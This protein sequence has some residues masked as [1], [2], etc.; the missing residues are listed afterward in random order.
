M[1]KEFMRDPEAAMKKY[2][3]ESL[4]KMRGEKPEAKE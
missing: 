3:A 2:G 4:E 1:E